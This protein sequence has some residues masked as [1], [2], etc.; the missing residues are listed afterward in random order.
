M[1]EEHIIETHF[2]VL[3][4]TLKVASKPL[5]ASRL[6]EICGMRERDVVKWL[7]VLE[8]SGQARL[9]NR[10]NG[11]YASWAGAREEEKDTPPVS[12]SAIDVGR[13]AAFES[14]IL[15]AHQR[16]DDA[17]AKEISRKGK[18]DSPIAKSEVP[19]SSAVDV[20]DTRL[21]RVDKMIHDL[22]LRRAEKEENLI[23]TIEREAR[24]NEEAI[25]TETL[26]KPAFEHEPIW[27]NERKAKGIAPDIEQEA[28]NLVPDA[29]VR[30]A[31]KAERE[32]GDE[33]AARESWRKEQE[34]KGEGA[35]QIDEAAPRERIHLPSKGVIRPK[36]RYAGAKPAK[37]DKMK[38]PAPVEISGVTLQFSERIERQMK[39][40]ERQARGI[41]LLRQEKEKLLSD[42]Y[43]PLQNRLESELETISDRVLRVQGKV[44]GLQKNAADLPAK[45][46]S[47]EK[48]QISSIKAH[49]EM[50]RAY[51]EACALLEESE[52]QLAE[53]R[54]RMEMILEQSRE[55]LSRHSAM[56]GE[57]YN[58]MERIEE[59]EADAADRVSSARAALAE[60]AE[61]LATAES[62]S[63]GLREL[64]GEIGESIAEMK[65]EVASAKRVLSDL[66][67]QMGQMRQIEEYTAGIRKE[68]DARMLEID[69]YIR[70]G[71]REFETLRESVEANFVRRYLRELRA[72]TES[73]SFEFG[74]AKRMEGDIDTRI[75]EERKKLESLFEE[76]KK[77][78][79][80]FETQSRA[81]ENPEK[82]ESRAETFSALSDLP[83]SRSQVAQMIAQVIGG[84]T[85]SLPKRANITANE[86]KEEA[87]PGPIGITKIIA[88]AKAKRAAKAKAR[89]ARKARKP[90]AKAA[91]RAGKAKA[92]R[93]KGGKKR[94]KSL[95][96]NNLQ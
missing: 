22:K 82:F 54:E 21:K 36:F 70:N 7:H 18:A 2:D 38:R 59:M 73:Y 47:V 40:I 14:D 76:G 28:R 61:R 65:R 44:A 58:T 57:L 31:W 48:V 15:L 42:H 62:H 74:Q 41:D 69:D 27:E 92:A 90:A 17:T 87:L 88:R 37:I 81:P 94:F 64:R 53:E 60:Q 75:A 19:V 20:A 16:E 43:L 24:E 3:L 89:A 46:S 8:K 51:D 35:A 26:P 4:S 80:L 12:P 56:S 79:Y 91:S 96:Q 83:S 1:G 93:K 78:S 86:R 84:R 29:P 50:R 11:I 95:P 5:S 6:A 55:E 39:R 33:E 67:R 30:A 68:Y 34:G 23:D 77:I 85:E 25:T 52:R 72:L 66:E 63:N 32:S 13:E 10:F 9:E 45:I 71:N 49:G